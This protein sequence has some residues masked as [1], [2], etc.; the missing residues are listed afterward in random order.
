M[1]TYPQ[2]KP[3]WN[4]GIHREHITRTFDDTQRLDFLMSHESLEIRE[5]GT[6]RAAKEESSL[7]YKVV[8]P[9]YHGTNVYGRGD[10]KRDALDAAMNKIMNQPDFWA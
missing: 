9:H 3:Y 8:W 7:K 10:T 6:S 4:D 5:N 2:L 1:S